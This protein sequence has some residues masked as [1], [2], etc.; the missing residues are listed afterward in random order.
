[1][2]VLLLGTNRIRWVS[3]ARCPDHA[4][5][6]AAIIR[7]RRQK[8]RLY[9]IEL[10]LLVVGLSFYVASVISFLLYFKS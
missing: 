10:Y 7:Y 1:M 8:T 9:V 6:L 5:T 3:Q 4:D 2:V